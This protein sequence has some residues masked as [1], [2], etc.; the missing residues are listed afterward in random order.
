[1]T[2]IFKLTFQKISSTYVVPQGTSIPIWKTV[3]G[4]IYFSEMAYNIQNYVF[5]KEVGPSLCTQVPSSKHWEL[6]KS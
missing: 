5:I 3:L 1:M 4:G 2:N 6:N